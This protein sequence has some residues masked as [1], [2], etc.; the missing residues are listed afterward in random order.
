MLNGMGTATNKM[1]E[2]PSEQMIYPYT[3]NEEYT[4]VN[5]I[6]KEFYDH[7]QAMDKSIY[8]SIGYGYSMRMN[9]VKKMGDAVSAVSLSSNRWQELPSNP[10]YVESLYDVLNM[11]GRLPAARDEVVIVT[12][13]YNR[14]NSSV[15]TALGVILDESD[16]D[17]I[18][19]IT[20]DNLINTVKIRAVANDDYYVPVASAP[21]TFAIP[22]DRGY[23]AADTVELK[24]VG[25]LRNK[26]GLNSSVVSEGLVYHSSLREYMYG[27][28]SAS[29]ILTAQRTNFLT[30]LRT[31]GSFGSTQAD[32]LANYLLCLQALGYTDPSMPNGTPSSIS[33]Y[34]VSFDKKAEVKK[35]IDKFNDAQTVAANKIFYQDLMEVI[36]GTMTTMINTISIALT[37]FAAISLIVS[38][39]M[40]AIITYVS[41][42]ERTKEIGILRSV[43]AR[44]M[45]ISRV[46]N[47]ETTIIGFAAGLM[48]VIIAWLLTI[49]INAIV[50]NIL[51]NQGSGVVIDNIAQMSV[52]IIF[53]MILLSVVLTLIAGFIP[54]RMAAKKDPVVALRT[55]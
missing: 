32:Q 29:A 19:A 18:P 35:Y 20:F 13:T 39:I 5:I 15:L 10:E 34:P 48:G 16:P 38:S 24:I 47:A 3:P 11:Q 44:K 54:S 50:R 33:I 8:N 51:K 43:G 25:I 53:G 23:N 22:A 2:F 46:F 40:I 7:L 30:D 41:V 9:L 49:P 4:G 37:A 52:L 6:T 31:N 42:I 26:Q 21:G 12:D 45:D 36:S 1:P 17:A 14:I 28:N 27:K 55:E